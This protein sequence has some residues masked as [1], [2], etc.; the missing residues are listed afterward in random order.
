[1]HLTELLKKLK[2]LADRGEGGEAANAQAMLDSLLKKNNMTLEHLEQEEERDYSFKIK[3]EFNKRLLQQ[4][5]RHLNPE[6]KIYD[7]KR[8]YV[9]EFGGNLLVRCTAAEYILIDQMYAHYQALMEK[10]MNLFYSAF[11]AAN[12]LFVYTNKTTDELTPEEIERILRR[13]R[14][15]QN[16]KSESF[17]RQLTN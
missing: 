5:A 7:V 10:E 13:D 6:I 8:Q 17:R 3:G 12:N 15:A 11:I 16:I 9:R 14:I 4:I 2:A 1:M